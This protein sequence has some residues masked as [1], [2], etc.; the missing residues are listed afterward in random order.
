MIFF[1]FKILTSIEDLSNSK[2]FLEFQLN[3]YSKVV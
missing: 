2:L 3:Y 1:K